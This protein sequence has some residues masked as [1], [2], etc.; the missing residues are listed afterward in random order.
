MIRTNHKCTDQN[1]SSVTSTIL[2]ALN[3]YNSQILIIFTHFLMQS[4]YFHEEY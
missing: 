4:D 2:K 3:I 1:Q